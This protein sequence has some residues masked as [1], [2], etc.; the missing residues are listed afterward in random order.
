MAEAT[1]KKKTKAAATVEKKAIASEKARTSA[2]KRSSKLEAKLGET[3]LKL[4][5]AASLN[6]AQVEE[7]ADLKV[8][9]EA[10]KT[11]GITRGL[12]TRKN[13][14]SPSYRKPGSW[15]LRRVGW[16]SCKL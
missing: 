13:R 4:A 11:N 14:Q 5:E 9:L 6:T 1:T 16:L 2:E 15:P 10:Y 8:A 7:L 3:K 12:L